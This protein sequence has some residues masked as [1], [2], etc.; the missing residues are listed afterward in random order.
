[1]LGAAIFR[2]GFLS[3]SCAAF[4]SG[5]SSASVIC[6]ARLTLRCCRGRRIRGN[7]PPTSFRSATLRASRRWS[8]KERA[9]SRAWLIAALLVPVALVGCGGS[10]GHSGAGTV[11]VPAYGVYSKTTVP[12]AAAP[13]TR[14]CRVTART[15]AGDALMFLA[16]IRPHGA[17]PADLYYV[18]MRGHLASFQA[19]RCD[20]TLLGSALTRSLTARQRRAL[21]AAL[22]HTMA[23]T[24]G[25]G[26]KRAG[27]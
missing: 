19:H 17:Y 18:I 9:V 6:T 3:V 21:V 23:G 5:V 20:V 10:S 1:V 14:V 7:G 16:H 24:V 4:G 26:L 15:F 11:T 27:T 22:P 12:G 8:D 25:E 2:D 13:G